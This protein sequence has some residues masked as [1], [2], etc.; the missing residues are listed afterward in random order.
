MIER[1]LHSR[2][3]SKWDSGKVLIVLG[4]RQVGKT[5]L[6]K[7]ICEAK[8]DYLY[9][10]GDDIPTRMRMEKTGLSELRQIIGEHKTVF[11]DEAQRMVN[12]GLIAKLIHDNIQG[13]RVILSGSSS[14]ELLSSVNE[15]LTGR[16]WEYHLFPVSYAEI[17]KH[18][19]YLHTLQSLDN[20]LVFGSYPDV[21]NHP[22]EE[23]AVL[24]QLAGSYLYKDLLDYHGIRKPELL[25]KLLIALALQV[26]AEVS[27]N[28]LAQLLAV[29]RNTVESYIGLLEQ[30]FVVFRLSSFSRNLRNEIRAGRKIYF[31]DNGI[32]NALINN[33]NPPGLRADKGALWENYIVS[34]R[35]KRNHYREFYCNSYFWRTHAQQEIDYMEEYNGKLSAFEIKYAV[36]KNKRMPVSFAGAYPGAEWAVIHKENADSF[37]G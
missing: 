9:L 6:V 29:D 2:L 23:V 35:M 16:K 1:E 26:G 14:L 4:P 12:I 28:E 11:I 7:S 33:F 3:L 34:E 22:G 24:K 31:Y 15:P 20:Y 10:T 36:T 5:T 37:L 19:G 18:Y 30:A 32:R 25:T 8:G 17:K 13:I 21:L 27:Y